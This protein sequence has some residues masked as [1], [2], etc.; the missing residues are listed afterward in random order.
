MEPP[1]VI[2]DD[3]VKENE[4]VVAAPTKKNA[5]EPVDMHDKPFIYCEGPS[6]S[7]LSNNKVGYFRPTGSPA[8][9][10][11]G[12]TNLGSMNKATSFERSP[13]VDKDIV[14][15]CEEEV[16]NKRPY[17]KAL[18]KEKENKLRPKYRPTPSMQL[19]FM[20][21][22]VALYAFAT[23]L[24][25]SEVIFRNKDTMLKRRD[26]LDI[27]SGRPIDPD[28]IRL[29]ALKLM[30]AEKENIDPLFWALPPSFAVFIPICENGDHWKDTIVQVLSWMDMG[31]Y[32]EPSIMGE[33]RMSEAIDLLMHPMNENQF[34]VLDWASEA[35][36]NYT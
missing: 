11:R 13:F 26:I 30:T 19:S 2:V 25:P 3:A 35:D 32:F 31:A 1:S 17:K 14:D 5:G 6:I 16:S 12:T 22:R 28:I 9:L 10:S 15:L 4:N 7:N 8:S 27:P 20:Q 21:E 34:I 33:V 23:Q 24:D 18:Q 36:N 29:V